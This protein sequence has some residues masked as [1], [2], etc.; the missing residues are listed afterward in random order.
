[1][2]GQ[3]QKTVIFSQRRRDAEKFNSKNLVK[4]LCIVLL[5]ELCAWFVLV[6]YF[7]KALLLEI[8][9]LSV[10]PYPTLVSRVSTEP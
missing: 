6:K 1:M 10:A 8:A 2:T 5:C 9:I 7:Y 3:E 4:T